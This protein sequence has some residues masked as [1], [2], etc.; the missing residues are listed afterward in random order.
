[1]TIC[2]ED[3]YKGLDDKDRALVDAGVERANATVRNWTK[4]VEIQGLD[5]LR[6]VGTQVY[7]N[8]SADKAKFSE[9]IRPNYTNIVSENIVKM[10]M[11]AAEKNR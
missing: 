4:K 5:A 10:F 11:D 9:L 3:W 6:K 7:V 2:S 8:T 1:V